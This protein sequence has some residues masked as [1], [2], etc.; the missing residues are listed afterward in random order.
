MHGTR[1]TVDGAVATGA[2]TLPWWAIHLNDWAGIALT[3]G[4]LIL[5]GFRIAIAYR[6]WKSKPQP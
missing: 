4:G 3:L 1:S 2:I 5:V 6:E